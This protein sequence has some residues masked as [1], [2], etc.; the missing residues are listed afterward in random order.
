MS[1][2]RVAVLGLG[3][4]VQP[5]ARALMDLADR[6][7]VV[8]A[9]SRTA[10]RRNSFMQA[11]PGIPVTGDLDGLIGDPTI[12]AAIV[13]T[14]PDARAELIG[15]LVDAG[16]HVLMEKPIERTGAAAE[17]IV[18][19]AERAGRKLGV[20]FQHRFRP[21]AAK[22]RELLDQGSLGSI[23]AAEISIPWWRPQSYY[24]QP[25]RGT[26][27][28][29]G[30]GVLLTQAIHTL[31]LALSLLGPVREVAAIAATS[32]MHRMETEDFVGAGLVLENGAPAAL[33]AT[34]AFYPG[35]QERITIAG[36]LGTASL[37][38]GALSLA[39]LDGSTEQHGESET[40]GGG[41]DPMAFS[42]GWHR[43]VIEDFLEAIRTD[44]QPRVSG[45]EGL[46]VIGLIDALLESAR[47]GRR[48][49]LPAG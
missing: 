38:G 24:D 9:W 8:A 42:H 34:T 44:R 47:S 1:R 13:L 19:H 28:R 22:L 11:F 37:V 20:V 33:M 2:Q 30:G 36:T 23:A 26:L 5:H 32:T 35:G 45:R 15:R 17:A 18:A 6:V 40:T 7:E 27:V 31:D 25:G 48:V 10:D 46:K 21:A 3:M 12:D 16:K 39:Y 49:A 43:A 41:A 14:T 4:A 29:D